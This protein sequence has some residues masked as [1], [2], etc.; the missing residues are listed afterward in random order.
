MRVFNMAPRAHLEL[1]EGSEAEQRLTAVLRHPLPDRSF[2]KS[3]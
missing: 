2:A 1:T 3:S